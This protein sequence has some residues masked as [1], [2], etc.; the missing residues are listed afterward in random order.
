MSRRT[1]D[2]IVV[3]S[4]LFAAISAVRLAARYDP[5]RVLFATSDAD[6]GG[7]TCEL[8]AAGLA[9]A[10]AA[11][12]LEPFMVAEWDRFAV[13]DG[14]L[15]EVRPGQTR[16]LDPGLVRATVLDCCA[17]MTVLTGVRT[18]R[19]FDGYLI[20]D[21]DIHAAE[22]VLKLPTL[23][24]GRS[25]VGDGAQARGLEYPVL[26][27]A[28]PDVSRQIIPVATDRLLVNAL[29]LNLHRDASGC[30]DLA[31]TFAPQLALASLVPD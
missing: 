26:L 15:A 16:L 7:S 8:F 12:R 2:A 3:G 29:P 23:P 14:D 31:A 17:A 19:V 30:I 10:A 20:V 28:L 18:T 6:V 9:D 11:D 21:G 22:T 27:D 5:E 24:A 4:G 25:F 1:F 13:V